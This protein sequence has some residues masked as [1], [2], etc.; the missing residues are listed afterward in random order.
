MTARLLVFG[1]F[2]IVSLSALSARAQSPQ[3]VSPAGDLPAPWSRRG[4]T[5][6]TPIGNGRFAF[7]VQY[8]IVF[9]GSNLPGPGASTPDRTANYDFF[10]QRV[11]LNFEVAANEN[12][13]A[14]VQAEFRGGWGGTSPGSSDPRGAEP[15]L[16]PFNRL[17][18]RGLRYT[19]LYWK[20][21]PTQQVIA[22]ILPLSDEFADTLFSA[23]WDWNAGGVAW[24]GGSDHS[25]WRLSTLNLVEGVGG[26]DSITVAHDGVMLTAD[27]GRRSMADKTAWAVDWGAH[28]YALIV[29]DHLPLGGTRDVWLGPT[30]A[31]RH[32]DFALR[33]FGI[34]NTGKLGVGSLNADGTVASGFRTSDARSHTGFAGRAEIEQ[35]VAHIRLKGQL[36]HTSGDR[37]GNIDRQF[38]T[39][40]ALLGTSGYW[41]YTHIFT[42]NGPSDVNDFGADIGNHGAGLTTAQGMA[43]MSLHPRVGLDLAAGW[44]RAA[45]ARRQGRTLGAEFAGNLRIQLSGPLNLDAGAAVAKLGDFFGAGEPTIYEVF[46]RLQLQF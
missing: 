39:P 18:D 46:S 22:G 4:D 31:L 17:D 2:A 36:I 45:E 9:D 24:L 19:Y 44:F 12:V 32:N 10:R 41:G 3:A 6:V 7:G 14:F 42:A 25:R 40:M 38:T 8:R 30:A 1:A 16:N 35:A 20:P 43:S 29:Q 23:D 26:S 27:Y 37:E 5:G 13:G 34:I 28:V 33:L 15:T 21:K 11:R